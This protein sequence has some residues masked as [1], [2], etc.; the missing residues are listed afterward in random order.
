MCSSE[1]FARGF[2][3][4]ACALRILPLAGVVAGL[5][6]AP[7]NHV[8]PMQR[9]FNFKGLLFLVVLFAGLGT[10]AFFLHRYQVR[11]NADGLRD[12]AE[13]AKE[14]GELA[15]AIDYYRRY[16]GFKPNEVNAFVEY[17]NLLASESVATTP[18]ARF[19]AMMILDLALRRQPEMDKE[20]RR[21]VELAMLSGRFSDAKSHLEDYLLKA[22]E[23]N[24]ELNGLLARCEY[25][26]GKYAEARSTYKKSLSNAKGEPCHVIENYAGLAKLLREHGGDVLRGTKKETI[27]DLQTEAYACIEQMVTANPKNP[28]ALLARAGYYRV[29]ERSLDVDELINTIEADVLQ[30]QRLAPTDPDVLL[31]LAD[32]AQL[33]RNPDLARQFLH[34][35]CAKHP[36]DWRLYSTLAELERDDGKAKAAI[37][38]L[39]KG[40]KEIPEQSDLLWMLATLYLNEKNKNDAVVTIRRL[41]EA[42]MTLAELDYL[43]ARLDVIDG[44]WPKAASKLEDSFSGLLARTQGGRNRF[45]T[46][47]AT[48]AGLLLGRCYDSIG[49]FDRAYSTYS[50]VATLD[51]SSALALQGMAHAKRSMGQLGEA[52]ETYK[53]ILKLPVE[54]RNVAIEIARLTITRNLEREKPNWEEIEQALN[55][56]ASRPPMSA[57]VVLMRLEVLN[58][59]KR[60]DLARP[61]LLGLVVSPLRLTF[62]MPRPEQVALSLIWQQDKLPAVYYV[63]NAGL[64]EMDGKPE[65]ALVWLEKGVKDYNDPL[66]L[67]LAQINHWLRRVPI[68]G[69]DS[70]EARNAIKAFVALEQNAAKYRPEERRLLYATLATGYQ[71]LFKPAEEKRLW[72]L[73]TKESRDDLQAA[74]ALFDLALSVQDDAEMK[75]CADRL[76][77]IEGEGGTLWRYGEVRRL[78]LLAVR[79]GAEKDKLLN[80]ARAYLGAVAVRRSSWPRVPLCEGML[81]DVEGRLDA[82]LAKYQEA[83]SRGERSPTGMKRAFELLV[84]KGRTSEAYQI[85][86]KMPPQM[87]TGDMQRTAAEVSLSSRDT[88]EAVRLADAAIGGAPKDAKQWLW[89]GQVYWQ[90]TQYDKAEPALRKAVEL[91]KT[92]PEAWVALVFYLVNTKQQDK[93][94]ALIPEAESALSDKDRPLALAQCYDAVGNKEKADRY[95]AS[96]YAIG[97]TDLPTLRAVSAYYLRN[98]RIKDAK[99]I[100]ELIAVDY[101]NKSPDTSAWAKRALALLPTVGKGN[102]EAVQEA[103]AA[104]GRADGVQRGADRQA[105]A[106]QRARAALLA[107]QQGRKNR[108]EAIRIL[109][110]LVDI[111]EAGT[112][113]AFLLAK[114]YELQGQWPR[115]NKVLVTMASMPNGTHPT[116]LA[117]HARAL[118]RNGMVNEARDVVTKLE[119][120]DSRL[121]VTAEV[122]AR[123][124]HKQGKTS[125]A[126]DLLRQRVDLGDNPLALAV[127]FEEIGAYSD[128]EKLFLA[129]VRRPGNAAKDALALVGFYARRKQADRALEVCEPLW[130]TC[131]P[132]DVVDGLLQIAT[133]LPDDKH[134]LGRIDQQISKALAAR[135]GSSVLA[136]ARGHLHVLQGREADAEQV[137]R[138]VIDRDKRDILAM[139]GL[140]WLLSLQPSKAPEALELVQ[141]AIQVSGPYPWLLDTQAMAYLRTGD[142]HKAVALLEDVVAETPTGPAYFHLAQAHHQVKNTSAARQA[143]ERAKKEGLKPGELHP[144]E[145]L[146]YDRLQRDLGV[147]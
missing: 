3:L 95:F 106:D 14:A 132:E 27:E 34:D 11:H 85:L 49:D 21:F 146:A 124:L 59:Q 127:L 45:V 77:K 7:P 116:Y 71:R 40:L 111:N 23:K 20:R 147:Q 82:A 6:P 46:E 135:P 90:A 9:R 62:P 119:A 29:Y 81:A 66:Y 137:Y 73:I 17:A 88:G 68:A 47:L 42:G 138:S 15:R 123:L 93:A 60:L 63:A 72:L 98:G 134:T 145:R 2:R 13:R 19:R 64:A 129:H 102:F 126:I 84:A 39:V 113:D 143:L 112:E 114:L 70:P 122:K 89:A 139:N 133:E 74:V 110:N 118:L 80:E 25:E 142:P 54:W 28:K 87:V 75:Q 115:A 57:E 136:T 99:P 120:V 1:N 91:G 108:L 55:V 130:K 121:F 44:D 78:L 12:R 92:L 94:V 83:I 48:Q 69:A 97:R 5:S 117:Y 38:V 58:F 16:L 61:Y 18:A 26:S 22:D 32:L 86:R 105:I 76:R 8:G 65:E 104:I 4:L 79:P 43:R 101:K 141:K 103:L 140:A 107:R 96:A 50:R 31:A 100:L 30:A 131:P 51:P 128:A 33:R 144:K 67:R 24:P 125:E 37:D 36:K 53:K 10:G 109:E 35:G 56:A 41:A 52:I